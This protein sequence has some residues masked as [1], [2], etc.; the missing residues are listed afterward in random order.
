MFPVLEEFICHNLSR[1][2]FQ[3]WSERKEGREIMHQLC[4]Y[5]VKLY[6]YNLI[7]DWD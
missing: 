5:Y 6:I 3:A 4:L 7:D 2:S 1:L